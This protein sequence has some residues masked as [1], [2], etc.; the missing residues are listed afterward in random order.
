MCF[1][2][3]RHVSLPS[4]R[5]YAESLRYLGDTL[6]GIDSGQDLIR[7]SQFRTVC[8]N[9]AVAISLC[10]TILMERDHTSQSALNRQSGQP[11]SKS[12]NEPHKDKIQL[13]CLI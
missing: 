6:L 3:K 10:M 4:P 11:D 13:A 2:P 5:L 7:D 8:R 12:E 9:K 1:G